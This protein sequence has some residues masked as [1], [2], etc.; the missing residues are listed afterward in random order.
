VRGAQA[1]GLRAVLVKTGKFR[2]QDLSLGIDPDAELEVIAELPDWWM[3][4]ISQ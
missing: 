4:T 1:A 3:T 2:E